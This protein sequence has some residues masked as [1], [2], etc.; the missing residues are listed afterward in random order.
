[1]GKTIKALQCFYTFG[2]FSFGKR[3][4]SAGGV[5]KSASN[6]TSYPFEIIVE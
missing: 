4:I 1:M 3:V 6:S 5:F 2:G